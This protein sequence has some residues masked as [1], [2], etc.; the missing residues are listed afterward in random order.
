MAI[1]LKMTVTTVYPFYGFLTNDINQIVQY[2]DE[3]W[4]Q[5]FNELNEKCYFDKNYKNST[6]YNDEYYRLVGDIFCSPQKLINGIYAQRLPHD[7]SE[8]CN[9]DFVIG[10]HKN[11]DLSASWSRINILTLNNDVDYI[12]SIQNK[13]DILNKHFIKGQQY[14]LILSADDCHCC[15]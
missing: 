1:K 12:N 4:K 3:E 8:K 6:E 9:Y 15:S 14:K 2:M 7:L 13:D 11:S 10:F 5:E